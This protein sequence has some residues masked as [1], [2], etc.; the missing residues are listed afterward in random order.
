M[1]I[2]ILY[3][4]LAGFDN[5][6][7]ITRKI[8]KRFVNG[9]HKNKIHNIKRF[10]SNITLFFYF[11]LIMTKFEKHVMRSLYTNLKPRELKSPESSFSHYRIPLF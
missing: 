1:I 6:L 5:N 11:L 8:I 4:S 10:S 7:C 3:H 2:I 9:V